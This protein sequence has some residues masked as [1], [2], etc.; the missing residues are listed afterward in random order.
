MPSASTL[1]VMAK[2]PVPGRVKTRLCPP[3]DPDQAAAI[4]EAALADTLEAVASCSAERRL[5]ALDGAPGAWLPAG[6]DVVAQAG[7]SFAERLTAAWSEVQGPGL[8]IGMDTPQVSPALL[9]LGLEA[10]VRRAEAAL[11]PATDGGWWAIGMRAPDPGVFL[12]VPMSTDETGARQLDA[13]RRAGLE[14]ELLPELDDI[15]TMDEARAV[16]ARIPASRT[17]EAVAAAD[18]AAGRR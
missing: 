17:A 6:F 3:C 8:Q 4:A 10:V 16:A 5:L 15:D 12:E 11:G 14:P 13:L 9:D 1:L 2:S 18:N 7:S